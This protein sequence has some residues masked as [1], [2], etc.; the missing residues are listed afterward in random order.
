MVDAQQAVDVD[1]MT[2]HEAT[3]VLVENVATIILEIEVIDAHLAEEVTED[4]VIVILETEGI[5]KDDQE[6]TLGALKALRLSIDRDAL[7]VEI[8]N[9]NLALIKRGFFSC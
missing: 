1:V 4:L 6:E 2:I 8:K 5:E 3:D 9:K 7:D